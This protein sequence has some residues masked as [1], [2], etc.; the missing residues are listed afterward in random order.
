MWHMI[1]QDPDELPCD[2]E[3]LP[4]D[5][6]GLPQVPLTET[7]RR[8]RDLTSTSAADNAANTVKVKSYYRRKKKKKSKKRRTLLE[9]W[10]IPPTSNSQQVSTAAKHTS[11]E[12]KDRSLAFSLRSEDYKLLFNKNK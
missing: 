1:T 8:L 2:P 11:Q 6:D 5:N 3:E 9:G 7:A 4:F 12:A 10:L